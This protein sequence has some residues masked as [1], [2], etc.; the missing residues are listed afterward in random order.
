MKKALFTIC[1]FFITHTTNI[2]AGPAYPVD[3]PD[4][5]MLAH[6]NHMGATWLIVDTRKEVQ[7][8]YAADQKMKLTSVAWNP[9]GSLIVTQAARESASNNDYGTE[10][11]LVFTITCKS[12]WERHSKPI[13]VLKVPQSRI[14]AHVGSFKRTEAKTKK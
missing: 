3:I 14:E 4:A 12:P 8:Y 7:V 13:R 10:E 6:T 2:N 11:L 5:I 9:E 1:L